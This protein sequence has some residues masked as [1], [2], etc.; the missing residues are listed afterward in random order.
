[1]TDQQLRKRSSETNSN[2]M[3]DGAKRP[4]VIESDTEEVNLTDL[5][6]DLQYI[7]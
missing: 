4:K 5:L 2:N 3:N 1:M 7:I 6:E